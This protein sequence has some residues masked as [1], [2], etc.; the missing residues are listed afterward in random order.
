MYY[1][2]EMK[3]MTIEELADE[4]NWDPEMLCQ[5]LDWLSHGT[6]VYR[7]NERGKLEKVTAAS[8]LK[9]WW[10]LGKYIIYYLPSRICEDDIFLYKVLSD[11]CDVMGMSIP[12]TRYDIH[13][14][15]EVP[16]W[17]KHS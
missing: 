12:L 10:M 14:K 3:T 13:G 9:K 6:G 5:L 15:H 16:E 2:E 4:F 17:V 1:E 8:V 11:T 7:S